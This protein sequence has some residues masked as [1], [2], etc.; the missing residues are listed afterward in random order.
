[1]RL[2]R[3]Q[4]ICHI[5][6]NYLQNLHNVFHTSQFQKYVL[7]PKR[8]IKSEPIEV[9]GNLAYK[10]CHVQIL[11]RRIKPRCN[12]SIPFAKVIWA[13]HISSKA[14]WET[15]EDIKNKYPYLFEVSLTSFGDETYFKRGRLSQPTL[16]QFC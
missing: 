11:D 6:Y 14:T 8:I 4:I 13:N 16:N 10:E 7:Y 9:T 12:K 2:L 1:M 5:D 3:S 15:K